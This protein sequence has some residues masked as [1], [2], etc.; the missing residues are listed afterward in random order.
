MSRPRQHSGRGTGSSNAAAASALMVLNNI[1]SK[2]S[3]Y[4]EGIK[5]NH[6][7][8]KQ[9]AERLAIGGELEMALSHVM[10]EN[11]DSAKNDIQEFLQE[12]RERLK[13]LAEKNVQGFREVDV[14]VSAL[15]GLREVVEQN[16]QNIEEGGEGDLPNYEENLRKVMDE[17]RRSKQASAVDL[18]DEQFCRDIRSKLGEKE[19]PKKRKPGKRSG[20]D[21]DDD[22][23]LEVINSGTQSLKC[24]MTA[25]LFE[26]PV[27]N[28]QCGHV[29]SRN[30]IEQLLQTN[31]SKACPVAGCVNHRV[32]REQLE[33]DLEMAMKVRKFKR[34]E[35]KEK[36][37]RM[38][39]MAL[40][41]D[42][43]AEME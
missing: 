12:Q 15:S 21:D 11:N 35:A 42:S 26:D 6:L 1:V 13:Q 7:T 18:R 19:P 17:H 22:D 30:G 43:D 28:K 41:D 29:Y 25:M 8:C 33:E 10:D 24:P 37:Q 32:E 39:Q 16:Q 34:R 9:V 36:Q 23:D 4:E 5:R 38:S 3:Q 27:R 31:G 40:D 2:K 14:F 20:D